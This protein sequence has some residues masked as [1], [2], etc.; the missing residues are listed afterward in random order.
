MLHIVTIALKL[1]LLCNGV[2]VIGL[3]IAGDAGA[4]GQAPLGDFRQILI[5]GGH[6]RGA[7]ADKAHVAQQHVENLRQLVHRGLAHK[8]ANL[9]H[10]RVIGAI[11]GGAVGVFQVGRIYVHRAQL[12]HFKLFAILT[13]ARGV[14]KHRASVT[15]IDERR[16]DQD[17]QQHK[18]EGHQTDENIQ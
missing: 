6:Q 18:G 10:S 13:A 2:A 9:S 11:E 3:S 12:E 8:A 1:F 16:H 15:E 14:I 5:R 4:R 17:G 7:R